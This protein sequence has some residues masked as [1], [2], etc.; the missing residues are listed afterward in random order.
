MPN[1]NPVA[2]RQAKRRAHKPLQMADLLKILTSAI[3]EAE[4]V[5]YRAAEAED[6]EMVLKSTHAVSQCIG[7]YSKLLEI[8]EFEARIAALEAA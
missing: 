6:H 1:P 8:G 7:Q 3:R 4:Q 5:L 2:A